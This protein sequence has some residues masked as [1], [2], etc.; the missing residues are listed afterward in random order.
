MQKRGVASPRTQSS[1]C[2]PHDLQAGRH[3]LQPV[4]LTVLALNTDRTG[5][6]TGDSIPCG[7]CLF[8]PSR[9]INPAWGTA[10]S[11]S[12][13]FACFPPLPVV[14]AAPLPVAAE[15]LAGDCGAHP[16][17]S[18]LAQCGTRE[19]RGRLQDLPVPDA[20]N[21]KVLQVI[22]LGLG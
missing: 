10:C 5:F 17:W 3:M 20:T 14:P 2:A 21:V 12:N 19:G 7:S 9:T 13:A 4:K 15:L 8:H 16:W 11:P 22:S 1:P 18:L 6:Y